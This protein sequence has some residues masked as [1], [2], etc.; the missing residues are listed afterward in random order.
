[1]VTIS[2]PDMSHIN[3]YSQLHCLNKIP[4][5]RVNVL[6]VE[7]TI[8]SAFSLVISPVAISKVTTPIF[9]AYAVNS[10]LEVV[11]K[12]PERTQANGRVVEKEQKE[13]GLIL[14]PVL[15]LPNSTMPPSLLSCWVFFFKK[16]RK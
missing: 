3:S 8:T 12:I 6:D 16:I 7:F 5:F 15:F 2:L 11:L 4:D 1:M 9:I 14:F 10:E 13:W